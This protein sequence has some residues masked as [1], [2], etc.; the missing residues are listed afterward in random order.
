MKNCQFPGEKQKI[1]PL[2][3]I[4][5]KDSYFEGENVIVS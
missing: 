4:L 1:P 3:H 5:T 2:G